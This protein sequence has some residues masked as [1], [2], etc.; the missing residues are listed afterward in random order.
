LRHQRQLDELRLQHER[1]VLK[2]HEEF[3]QTAATTRQELVASFEAR[4]S[5]LLVRSG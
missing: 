4:K 5:K 3:S 2:L 1:N